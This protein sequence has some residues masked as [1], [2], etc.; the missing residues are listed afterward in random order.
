MATTA[1]SE[2]VPVPRDRDNDYTRE[3]AEQRREFAEAQSGTSLE[4]VSSYSFDP[5]IL[6]GN[7]E[8][9]VGVAQVP[10]GLAGP[11][12]VNG[13]HARGEFYVPMATA[14]GT[15]VASYNRGMRLLYEA[16]GV[17]TTIMDD[18]MQRAPAFLFES[19]RQARDFG[20]WLSE[21]FELIKQAAETTT[22]SGKL[23]E[24][25][26]YTA[27][28]MVYTRFD[29]TT[30]D[31]A[32][33]NLTGKAT[34]AAC[35]W[36]AG[37]RPEIDHFFL[38]SNFATD[39]KSSQV[40]MLHTRGKRVIAEATIP[41]E[42]F[43]R[44]MRSNTDLM[45]RAR[46]VSN[47][48]GFMSGVNNNGAHSANGI[49]AMF[50]ATGQDAAN[51]AESSAAFIYAERRDNGD[52]YYSVTIPSLIVATYGGGTGLATQRECLELLGCSG[53]GKVR[54]FTEIV[55]ATVLCGELS[56]GSAIVAEE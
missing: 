46:Q 1:G 52:Y 13:E 48:G 23:I 34:A 16:G 51:V 31:A 7:V 49:T 21:S 55:A 28:R 20:E 3:A 22:K 25:E 50:I 35:A 56:L 11:L 5:G 19:A 15:L 41:N 45:Y 37:Q 44:I 47:L 33:Q 53:K 36:I 42:L 17:T 4:H 9:F 32:G 54:K 38:E 8:Q 30:G 26:Q 10:I 18:R 43:E 2:R 40:N 27:G 12:L 39:K 14:E 24:I 6:T 29:Y